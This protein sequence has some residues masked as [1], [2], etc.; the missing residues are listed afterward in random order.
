MGMDLMQSEIALLGQCSSVPKHGE[1]GGW[2][3]RWR[4]NPNPVRS[5]GLPLDAHLRLHLHLYHH[6]RLHLYLY[7]YVYLYLA[8]IECKLMVGVRVGIRIGNTS[9][10]L[11]RYPS[12]HK[13]QLGLWERLVTE[14]EES[15]GP[16]LDFDLRLGL[17][18]DFALDVDLGHDPIS[19]PYRIP[20]P[21]ICPDPALSLT[22]LLAM[23]LA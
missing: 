13:V 16:D 14:Q 11:G 18:P 7:L 20:D 2:V 17:D 5:T 4:H 6:S 3:W 1:V 10:D 8:H 9:S 19:N 22:L 12:P 23:A 15:I 21:V